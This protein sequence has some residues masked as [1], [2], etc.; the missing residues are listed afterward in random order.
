MKKFNLIC[1][2][3]MILAI[4]GIICNFIAIENGIYPIYH[5]VMLVLD[6]ILLGMAIGECYLGNVMIKHGCDFSRKEDK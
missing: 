4:I 2:F 1:A 6:G 3:C 5:K